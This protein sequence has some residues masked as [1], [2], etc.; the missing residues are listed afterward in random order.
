MTVNGVAARKANH[1]VRIAD[2]VALPQGAIRRTV[3]VRAL[4]SRRGP[5]AEACHLYDEAAPP[6][7]LAEL[8]QAW[9]P[10][11]AGSEPGLDL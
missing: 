3:R 2:N 8:A 1:L 4:G 9:E 7:R 6:V 11:L 10:L 5:A